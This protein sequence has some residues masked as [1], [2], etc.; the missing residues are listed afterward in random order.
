LI[1][2]V[3]NPVARFVNIIKSEN[4]STLAAKYGEDAIIDA[5]GVNVALNTKTKPV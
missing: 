3:I 1:T 5:Q 2:M 4:K